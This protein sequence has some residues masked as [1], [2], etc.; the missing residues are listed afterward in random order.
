[1]YGGFGDRLLKELGTLAPRN[2]KI[3]IFAPP[4]RQFT[5][6]IGGSLLAALSTFKKMW[7][8]HQ[9]YEEEGVGAVHRKTFL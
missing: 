5:T 1:M 9:E 8:S 2:T 3:K 7:I 6:W 4:E